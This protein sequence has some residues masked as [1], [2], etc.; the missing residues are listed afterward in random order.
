MKDHKKAKWIRNAVVL[1]LVLVLFLAVVVIS[2]MKQYDISMKKAWEFLRTEWSRPAVKMGLED[3]TM[4]ATEEQTGYFTATLA[5][6]NCYVGDPSDT[7]KVTFPAGSY[8]FDV[9]RG[10]LTFRIYEGNQLVEE[11]TLAEEPESGYERYRYGVVL[12]EGQVIEILGGGVGGVLSDEKYTI[13]KEKMPNQQTEMYTLEAGDYEIGRD[14][15]AGTASFWLAGTEEASLRVSKPYLGG[16]D[17]TLVPD[18]EYNRKNRYGE[19]ILREGDILQIRGGSV[20]FRV[21]ATD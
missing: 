18:E 12:K 17:V 14:V 15:A 11:W 19:V 21:Q 5:Q 8:T 7:A 20:K 13:M 10:E 4:E 6:G 1:V 16:A 9:G 2:T 3:P